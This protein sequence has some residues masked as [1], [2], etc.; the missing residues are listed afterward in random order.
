MIDELLD[1]VHAKYPKLV[2]CTQEKDG[3]IIFFDEHGLPRVSLDIKQI[4]QNPFGPA[5]AVVD[6]FEYDKKL[7]KEN[8]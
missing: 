4:V 6:L 7:A 3:T 1:Q 5:Q 2:C 8:V